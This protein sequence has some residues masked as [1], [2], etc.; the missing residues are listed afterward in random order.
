MSVKVL[1]KPTRKIS[2][3][4]DPEEKKEEQVGSISIT[5]VNTTMIER[6]KERQTWKTD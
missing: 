2:T 1:T 5:K 3:L 6:E 4:E